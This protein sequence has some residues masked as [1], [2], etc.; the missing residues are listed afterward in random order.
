MNRHDVDVD[1]VYVYASSF[2]YVFSFFLVMAAQSAWS[3]VVV[4]VL[5]VSECS[6]VAVPSLWEGLAEWQCLDCLQ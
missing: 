1:D 4:V 5:G 3:M 2:F 6:E